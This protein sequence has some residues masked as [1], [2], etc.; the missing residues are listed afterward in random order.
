MII[1]QIFSLRNFL[2]LIPKKLTS[3]Y[4]LSQGRKLCRKYLHVMLKE[5][6]KQQ[7]IGFASFICWFQQP[8]LEKVNQKAFQTSGK[9]LNICFFC[10]DNLDKKIWASLFS[11]FLCI[12]RFSSS[13]AVKLCG[14][15]FIAGFNPYTIYIPTKVNLSFTSI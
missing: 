15:G 13:L 10:N 12:L 2:L 11:S 4:Y 1:W 5:A 3:R 7:L 14:E 9:E 8:S 6:G